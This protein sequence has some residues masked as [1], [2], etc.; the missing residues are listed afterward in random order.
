[1]ARDNLGAGQT[2]R[3]IGHIE[4]SVIIQYCIGHRQHPIMN[5]EAQT[6]QRKLSDINS[7]L[8]VVEL[9]HFASQLVERDLLSFASKNSILDTLGYSRAKQVSLL[10]DAVMAQVRTTPRKFEDF[11]AILSSDSSLQRLAEDVMKTYST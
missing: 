10:M 9:N 11:M 4:I 1:M 3:L 2:E 8:S 6:L 5:P 7:L